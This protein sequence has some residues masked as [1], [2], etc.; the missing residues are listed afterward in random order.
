MAFRTPHSRRRMPLGPRGQLSYERRLRISLWCMATPSFVGV[1]FWLYL[2]HAPWVTWLIAIC[3]L[4][5]CLHFAVSAFEQSLLRPLQTLSNVL[6]ALRTGDYS[7]RVRGGRRND[8]LGD[9]AIE[10]N[11]LAND[12]QTERLLSL[13]S[14]T[15]ARRILSS[16]DVPAFI[17]DRHNIVQMANA[18]AER[19]LW[20]SWRG[21][22][23]AALGL[24]PA[25][26]VNE[27][28]VV[29]LRLGSASQWLVRRSNFRLHGAPHVLLL[30]SDVSHALRDE[31]RQ[32][33]RRLIRVLGHE[34][35]NSLTPIKSLAGSL[36]TMLLRDEL[37]SEDGA[38]AL[39]VIE[40][41][42]DSLNRFLSGYRQLAQLPL[43]RKETFEI[44]ELVRRIA[45][46]DTRVEVECNGPVPCAVIADRDQMEQAVIN[47]L[48]NAMESTQMARHPSPPPIQITWSTNHRAVTL[49]I[50]DSG[51]GI[52]NAA[53]LFVPFYTTKEQGSGLGLMLVKQIV[54]AHGGAVSLGNRTDGKTGA[55]AELRLPLP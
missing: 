20:R 53:N 1:L 46:L 35:N 33:W 43:P 23:V 24:S 51:L 54:E 12:L 19:L 36:R 47:L 6:V 22:T 17:I 30:L 9:L 52:G 4:L 5:F 31:E 49:C 55:C 39:M 42:A 3:L 26:D 37:T 25:M 48:R 38:N 15:M 29:R 27:G 18:A 13:E 40:E 14:G 45:Q 7:L 10:I 34:I 11:S 21:Q 16:I 8:A 41:R 32:A 28:E 2:R 44:G 50:I